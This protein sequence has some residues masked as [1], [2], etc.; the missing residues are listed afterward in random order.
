[1]FFPCLAASTSLRWKVA[2]WRRRQRPS[3]SSY[4]SIITSNSSN[5]RRNVW[6]IVWMRELIAAVL[7]AGVRVKRRGEEAMGSR[8]VRAEG[9][10][11]RWELGRHSRRWIIW[12]RRGRLL[13]HWGLGRKLRRIKCWPGGGHSS[14]R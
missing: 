1:M 7:M 2:V 12:M 4:V 3:N 5:R 10:G 9:G 6:A 8:I 13:G 14:C 11:G